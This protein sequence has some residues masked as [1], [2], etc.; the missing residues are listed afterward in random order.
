MR[1][2]IKDYEEVP[3]FYGAS[4]FDYQKNFVICH[5]FPLNILIGFVRMV[6]ISVR[7]FIIRGSIEKRIFESGREVGIE[8][9]TRRC[10]HLHDELFKVKFHEFLE[11]ANKVIVSSS[12]KE[13]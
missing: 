11:N 2:I 4:W 12:E 6:W 1:K 8:I 5:P 7:Y 13:R 9:G 3:K 10:E